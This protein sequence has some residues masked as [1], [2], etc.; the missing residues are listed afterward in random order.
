MYRGKLRTLVDNDMLHD[1]FRTGQN[2][3]FISMH[4]SAYY[5]VEISRQN[6]QYWRK[7]W[8]ARSPNARVHKFNMAK[9]N[10]EIKR[11]VKVRKPDQSDWQAKGT[12]YLDKIHNYIIVIP[13]LHM[14]YHHRDALEFI[15]YHVSTAP[16]GYTVVNTG[17]EVDNHGISFHDADPNLD[18]AGIEL[19]RSREALQLLHDIVPRQFLCH[20]NHGSLHYRRAKAHGI[21]VEYLRTYRE[22]LFPDTG[23]E[24][25]EWA[26]SHTF[27]TRLGP[28][29]VKHQCAGDPRNAAAHEGTNLIVGHNHSRFDLSYGASSQRLYWGATA[30]CLLDR[31]SLA[32]AYGRETANKPILGLMKVIDGV[33]FHFPMV[34]DDEGRWIDR[35]K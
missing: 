4:L 30:G 13:D 3:K 24:L 35:R 29:Q 16:V 25:W 17:D 6:V 19:T 5:E 7:Q 15:A 32:F 2:N 31:E 11:E 14:P 20:S 21:P 26:Y 12:M 1:L 33:P 22:V 34:L 27:Q 28:V 18:S 10:R 8:E 9:A 23:G